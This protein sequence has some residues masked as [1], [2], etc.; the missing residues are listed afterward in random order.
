MTNH[1]FAIQD[2]PSQLINTSAVVMN[3]R[4]VYVMPG[5]NA[6]SRKGPNQLTIECLD[7][8]S[9]SKFQGDKY[10]LNY[11]KPIAN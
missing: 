7:T 5:N 4:F 9:Q 1:W 11:G 3:E 2:I 10:S 8:G 6:D